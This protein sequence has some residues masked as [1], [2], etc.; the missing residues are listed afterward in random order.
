MYSMERL[1]I[2]N[3]STINEIVSFLKKNK[4]EDKEL[5]NIL[6]DIINN[7]VNH[8]EVFKKVINKHTIDTIKNN[9]LNNINT[10][11]NKK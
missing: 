9:K 3:S 7:N 5:S 6:N 11:D 2:K 4:V 8:N 10:D 1:I